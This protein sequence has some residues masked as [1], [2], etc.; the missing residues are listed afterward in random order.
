ME[1]AEHMNPCSPDPAESS[2][3]VVPSVALLDHERFLRSELLLWSSEQW[4][5]QGR[6]SDAADLEAAVDLIS[7]LLSYLGTNNGFIQTELPSFAAPLRCRTL[8]RR[9][10]MRLWM[11]FLE[12]GRKELVE[13][14]IAAMGSGRAAPC[15]TADD[16]FFATES[17]LRELLE[18]IEGEAGSSAA[19]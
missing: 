4:S 10:A 2:G 13:P 6:S 16:A 8:A 3:P 12:K 9:G 18:A 14:M 11:A 7:R 1:D 15:S 5:K 19:P 17:F